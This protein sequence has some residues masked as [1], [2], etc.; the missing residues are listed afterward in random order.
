MSVSFMLSYYEC[1]TYRA[2][3][4]NKQLIDLAP[5][6]VWSTCFAVDVCDSATAQP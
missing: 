6:V 2:L 4:N 5:P 1:I 3:Y